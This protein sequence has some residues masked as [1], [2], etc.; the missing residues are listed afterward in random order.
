[1]ENCDNRP[2][3]IASNAQTMSAQNTLAAVSD[4]ESTQLAV[5]NARRWTIVWL[6]FAASLINYF[7]RQTLAYAMPLLAKDFNLDAAQQGLVLSAF[8]WTYTYLQIP[9]GLCADRFNLRWL[10]AG[11]FVI[12]S[13]AQGLT[14]FASSIGMLIGCR[15]L[16]GIGESSYLVG[17]TKVV[18]LFFPLSQRGLPCGLFDAGTRTGLVLE[19][20]TIG[21]LL[22]AFG[23]RTTF[24]LVGFAALLWLL[25]WF[26]ATPAQMRDTSPGVERP[27]F[28]WRQFG[29]VLHS[30]DLLG[31][32][33]GFF[34][35]DYYWY[36]LI[37]WLPS[38][39]VNV[40][41][42]TILEAGIRASL[43]FLVF[44]ICQPLGGWMADR[45]IRRGWEPARARKVIISL[46]FLSGLLIIPAAYTTSKDLALLL[47]MGGCL[48]GLS[49]AN[50]LVLLQSCTP[51]KEIGLAVGIYNF[52]G[53]MAGIVQPLVTGLVI[54]LSGGSYTLAFV[55][56]GVMLATSTLS[57]WF[58]VGPMRERPRDPLTP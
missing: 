52:V 35:F 56:A 1:L 34:C 7:D 42:V 25:P 57:Y 12:W 49:A 38:Y 17:G 58:I 43:P 2:K 6:L 32:L 28:T 16:L 37:T 48:V 24:I 51:P 13:L 44:G 33:L 15:M 9:I 30:R 27:R 54:K 41:G 3:P 5:S 11:A 39:F 45:V 50:Q 55:L 47:I 10:Y 8:F 23:W 18:S 26:V 53:N 21:M 22:S 4:S 29:S 46:A 20:L 14:G 36:F 19:G 40:R 31:V